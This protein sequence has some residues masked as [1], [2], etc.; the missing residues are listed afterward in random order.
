MRV[1]IRAR[2]GCVIYFL[3]GLMVFVDTGIERTRCDGGGEGE[4]AGGFYVGV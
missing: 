1:G 3:G 2:R 4:G